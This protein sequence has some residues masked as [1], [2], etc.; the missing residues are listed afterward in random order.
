MAAILEAPAA[1]VHQRVL[2]V[3]DAPIVL[4]D[5]VNAFSMQLTGHRARVIPQGAL[6]VLARIGDC[7]VALG[8]RAPLYSSRLRSMT[9]DYPTPMEPTFAL[10]GPPAVSLEDGVRETVAWLRASQGE[11]EQKRAQ[12]VCRESIV[13]SE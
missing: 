7:F 12:A 13:G 3:G 11:E 8:V 4:L 9:E 1:D 10:L 2:Y 5:W 6:R